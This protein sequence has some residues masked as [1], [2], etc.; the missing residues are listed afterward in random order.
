MSL[1]LLFKLTATPLLV[2][3]VSV[4]TR[5]GGGTMAGLLVGFPIMTGPLSV[6]LALEQGPAFAAKAAVGI[7]NA[8]AGCTAFALAYGLFAR[9][10]SWQAT[11]AAALTAFFLVTSAT[12]ALGDRLWPAIAGTALTVT[13]ALCLMPRARA[14]RP[15]PPPPWWDIWLRMVL[16]ALLILAITALAATLGAR[17]SGIFAALPVISSIIGPFTQV[18]S[19]PETAIRLFRAMVVSYFSFGLFFVIV[20]LGIETHGIAATYTAAVLA[21]ITASLASSGLDHWIGRLT[22]ASPVP[23]SPFK[24]ASLDQPAAGEP[25]SGKGKTS[26]LTRT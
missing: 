12:A 14:S 6:F 7:L 11:L 13:A 17:L 16:T 3:L 4:L 18:R 19:G 15:S 21:C 9:T 5:R 26:D 8:V 2:A 10:W 25:G 22:T 23:Q 20:G 1:I 24:V